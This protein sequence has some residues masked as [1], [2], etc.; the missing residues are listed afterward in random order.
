MAYRR[1]CEARKI[2]SRGPWEFFVSISAA[3]MRT[4]VGDGTICER[5][6]GKCAARWSEPDEWEF[7][8]PLTYD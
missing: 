6:N 3:T 7:R 5:L 1:P 8:N 2:G 4:G